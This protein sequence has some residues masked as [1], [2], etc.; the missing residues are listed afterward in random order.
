MNA[1]LDTYE[2]TIY[3]LHVGRDGYREKLTILVEFCN[4]LIEDMPWK[5]RDAL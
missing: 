3:F 1:K 5:L 2:G 4:W